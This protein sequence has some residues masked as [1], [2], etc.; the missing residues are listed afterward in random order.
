VTFDPRFELLGGIVH[1]VRFAGD[2]R[3]WGG[4]RLR[5]DGPG[6]AVEEDGP[7]FTLE[8]R[9]A[10][11]L[12]GGTGSGSGAGSGASDTGTSG[13][14]SDGGTSGSSG[15]SSGGPSGPSGP[16]LTE[17][18]A[19]GDVLDPER[20]TCGCH[21]SG[22]PLVDIIAADRLGLGDASTAWQALVG[23]GNLAPTGF[24][25]VVPGDPSRSHLVHKLLRRSDGSTLFGVPGDP[26]PPAKS[27]EHLELVRVAQWILGGAAP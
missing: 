21:V 15:S 20:S 19:T 5:T 6:W 2:V 22:D 13:T 23:E 17:L 26:M 4:E 1:R 3:G 12:P 24:A 18:F 7:V 10:D 16:S 11:D 8:F 9:T 14:G 27:L 25:W